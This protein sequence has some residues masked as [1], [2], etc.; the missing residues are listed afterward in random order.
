LSNL[1]NPAT[2]REDADIARETRSTQIS[3]ATPTTNSKTLPTFFGWDPRGQLN[4]PL[5]EV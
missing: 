3:T 2:T 4:M 5:G 1:A